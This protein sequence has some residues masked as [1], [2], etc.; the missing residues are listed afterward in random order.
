M[1]TYW[2]KIANFTYHLS[3]SASSRSDLFRIYRK[4]LQI[5]KLEFSRQ[6]MVKIWWS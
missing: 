1:A 5:L 2:L 3:F 4:A 6:P